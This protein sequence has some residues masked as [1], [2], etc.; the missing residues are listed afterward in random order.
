MLPAPIHSAHPSVSF[1]LPTARLA[2]LPALALAWLRRPTTRKMAPGERLASS[3]AVRVADPAGALAAASGARLSAA[4][5]A[6]VVLQED[7]AVRSKFLFKS[8]GTSEEDRDLLKLRGILP[9]VV[10]SVEIQKARVMKHLAAIST[11]LEKYMFLAFLRNT[12][13][14][15]LYSCLLDNLEELMPIIYTPTVGTA[16][17]QYSHI[18][19]FLAPPGVPDGL[20]VAHN[21]LKRLD[22]IFSNW[23]PDPAE[24]DLTPLIAVVTDGSR[25]LGL[26]DQ[27]VG[28]MGI[29]VGF[30]IGAVVLPRH[31]LTSRVFAPRL[32]SFNC[33]PQLLVTGVVVVCEDRARCRRFVPR[34]SDSRDNG[35]GIDPRRTLPITLDLG[36]DNEKLLKDEL[37]IGSR[38]RRLDDREFH[39]FM[40]SFLAALRTKWPEMLVQFEDFS[41]NHAL[42]LLQRHRERY[43]CFNDDIQGTGAVILAGFINGSAT[44]GVAQLLIE[45]LTSEAGLS[46]DDAR[47]QIWLVDSKGLVTAD[48]GGELPEGRK[49]FARTDNKGFQA[50]TLDECIDYVRPTALIGFSSQPGAFSEERLRKMK[51]LNERPIVFPLSNPADASEC[52]FETAMRSTDNT[53]LFAS[54]TAFP[55]YTIPGTNETK[56]YT[57]ER[58]AHRSHL[59]C[60]RLN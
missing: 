42:E 20:F 58:A 23:R 30:L 25:I 44:V 47:R 35:A 43:F 46:E 28:G 39:A 53:V 15:L 48:R 10:E 5:Q 55:S 33:I 32:E 45:F 38:R 2:S 16:C 1:L 4:K 7:A 50:R 59:L 37:Y 6:V 52:D 26:G 21:D 3:S 8:T 56:V 22:Q 24:P 27:G 9:P 19:P 57:R 13:S 14:A 34:V 18:Y 49:A 54:G 51:A 31:S 11:P 40:D 41:S 60:R 29:P 36:T 12:N 17:V